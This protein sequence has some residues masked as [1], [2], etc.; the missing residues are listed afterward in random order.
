MI[1]FNVMQAI[2]FILRKSI[3]TFCWKVI[4]F[5]SENISKYIHDTIIIAMNFK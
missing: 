5:Y 4:L 3:L 1:Q 2:M